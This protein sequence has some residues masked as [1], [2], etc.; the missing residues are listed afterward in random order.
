M[1][2]LKTLYTADDYIY[3]FVYH[4]PSVQPHMQKITTALIPYS[5]WNHYL[6]WNG[7]FVAHTVVQFFMQFNSKIPFDIFNSLIFV[8]LMMLINKLSIKLSGKKNKL[9]IVPFIFLFLW[10]FLPSFGQ[11]VLW[12]SG[13][14]NYLWM[15]IIYL[16]FIWFNLQNKPTTWVQVLIAIVLGFLT[17]A[18]NENSGPAAILIVLLFMWKHYLNER[19]VN[20]NSVISVIFG[21][22]G[23]IVMMLAP[24]NRLRGAVHRSIGQM[25]LDFG[26]IVYMSLQEFYVIYV[27]MLILLVVVLY[28]KK[29]SSDALIS[30]IIFTIGHFASILVLV[31]SPEHPQRTFFGGA[32]FLGIAFFILIYALF[33][34][35]KISLSVLT[36]PMLILFLFS[37]FN[38]YQDIDK[39][40]QQIAGQYETIEKSHSKPKAKQ[41]PNVKIMTVAKS[42]YN[43]Y[44]GTVGLT[45]YPNAWMNIWESKFFDVNSISGHN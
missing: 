1:L 15:S 11:S 6:N 33:N 17:G 19:Q 36:V 10:F 44:S 22:C 38:A 2:N 41:N 14:G 28:Y 35:A 26:Q 37:F 4:T 30:A 13:A 8:F 43:A 16:G 29:I 23:F 21:A 12:V 7:R 18:S 9:F 25:V 34:E 27:L 3:R 40:Y 39:S 42:S 32:V 20:W 45:K 31:L 24:G 5:M